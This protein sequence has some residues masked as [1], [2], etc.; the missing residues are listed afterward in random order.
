MKNKK[1][2]IAGHNGMV[3]SSVLKT[4]KQKGYENL[5]T[6][7]KKD[8]NLLDQKSVLDF[9]KKEKFDS[10]ILCAAK[11]GGIL[12]NNNY[13]ADF[14]YDN[15]QIS[16]N[17]IKSCSETKVK[18]L[19]NL[20]SSC[21]YPREAKLPIKEEYLLTGP[22]EYTNEPYAI[23]KISAIEI[24]RSLSKQYGHKVLNLMPTNLYGPGD[25]FSEKDSHVIPGLI[26]RL[27]KNIDENSFEIW[28][29]G[30]PLREFL[31]VYDLADCIKFIIESSYVTGSVINVD[32]GFN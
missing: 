5:V 7:N 10:V 14:I 31:Y 9:F 18:K 24:G 17:I 20:G 12:A 29:T 27:S 30:K 6:I 15:I 32:G 16:S 21:I 23:A 13:R 26:H 11:V 28:G 25:N 3:G 1:I 19:I 8:L 22:L 2:F 4:L